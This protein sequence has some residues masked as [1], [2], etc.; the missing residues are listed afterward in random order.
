MRLVVLVKHAPSPES[1]LRI[2]ADGKGVD[3]VCLTYDVNE[4]D[5]YAVEEAVRLKERHGGE[6]VAVSVGVNC[7]ATLRKCLA[8]GADRAVKVPVEAGLDAVRVA[9]AIVDV[10]RGEPFDMVLSGFMSQD[11]NNALVGVLV[12]AMLDIPFATAVTALSVEGGE[13]RAVRELEGGYL[14]EVLLPLPCLITVQSG[15][16]EP[17]YISIIGV[18]AAKSKELREHA[19]K[20]GDAAVLVERVYVPPARRAEILEGSPSEV[21]GKL[22]ELI[23]SKGVV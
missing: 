12:A 7:D 4:W 11:A 17:R 1:T 5:R 22:V 8:M 3:P 18:K 2:S 19:V 16:N 20:L 9:E 23:S 13:V 6:V 14:E 10:L 21:A 15:I